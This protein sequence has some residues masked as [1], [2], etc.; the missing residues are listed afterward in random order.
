MKSIN[1]ATQQVIKEFNRLSYEDGIKEIGKSRR[2]FF[3]WKTK[4]IAYRAKLLKKVSSVLK[5]NKNEYAEIITSEMGKPI[6][7]SIKEIEKCA[8]V[9][10]YYAENSKRMLKDETVKTEM[11]K[12]Y[13]SFEPLGI[14]LGIMPWNFPFWQVFRFAVPALAAG[15]ACLLK[16]AS[17]VPICS[18][19]IEEIFNKS[20]MKNVFK[21]L[22]IDSHTAMELIEN[23]L[24]NGVSLTGS[25]GAGKKIAELSGKNLKKL[26]L[27]LGGSDPYIVLKDADL[28]SCCATAIKA[29]MINSGQSCIAAKRFIVVKEVAKEFEK[30][31]VEQAKLLKVGNPMNENTTIGPLAKLELADALELQ[32]KDAVSKGAKILYGGYRLKGNF[33]MPGIITNVEDDMKILT[34]ETFGPIA[35]I[36]IVKDEKEAIKVANNTE[37]GL[38][39]SIWTRNLKKAEKLAKEIQTGTVFINGMVRS[40]PRLPFGGIKNSG[41]GRELSHYGIKEFVNIKTVVIDK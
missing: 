8:W 27:E 33:F 6:T 2:A 41:F 20:G 36:I 12:S 11:K 28:K 39:A 40:D 30:L 29:R 38:G 22:L 13:V 3:E 14:I 1:P 7:E 23:G 15:N 34:E 21:S 4:P 37:F 16:H 24:I 26:V 10:E 25:V 17:N 9:C 32:I 18:T 31:F 19:T 5:R 35:P